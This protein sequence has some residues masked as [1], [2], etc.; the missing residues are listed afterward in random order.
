MSF[1]ST[2]DAQNINKILTTKPINYDSL[3]KFSVERSRD[4]REQISQKYSQ[5]FNKSLI[6]DFKSY[7]SGDFKDTIIGLFTPLIDY[8]CKQLRKSVKG[9]GTD[10]KSLID[11][12]AMRN[13]NEIQLIRK[14]YS[15]IYPKRDLLKDIKDDTS[16]YFRKLLISLITEKRSENKNP[17][18]NLCRKLG[19][20]LVNAFKHKNDENSQKIITEIF[21]T[22]S[23]EEF[24]KIAKYYLTISGISLIKGL[25]KNFKGSVF[26]TLEAIIYSLLSPA[27]YYS[28]RINECIVGLGTDDVSLI[29]ILVTRFGVDLYKIKQFYRQNYKKDVSEDIIGDTSGNYKKLLVEIVNH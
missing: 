12:L 17:D 8:D 6:E 28:K 10:K 5:I 21:T 11:I 22:K 7:L 2:T 15:E 26:R 20:E 23:K 19:T 18:E 29:R 3:I 1:D 4:I 13:S 9:L 16:G 24:E 14:R 27:E 25:E